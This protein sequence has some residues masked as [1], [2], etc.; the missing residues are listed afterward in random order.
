MVCGPSPWPQGF[1]LIPSLHTGTDP[2]S[3]PMCAVH[4]PASSHFTTEP[5]SLLVEDGI[6]KWQSGSQGCSLLLSLERARISS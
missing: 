1:K 5:S 4:K 3:F 6:Q 2:G